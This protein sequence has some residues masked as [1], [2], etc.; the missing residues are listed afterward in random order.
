MEVR[1]H[2]KCSGITAPLTSGGYFYNHKKNKIEPVAKYHVKCLQ[3]GHSIS[4][5]DTKF[6]E[7]DEGEK[8]K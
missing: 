2:K 6:I 7:R 3:C 8:A 1:I 5:K 4:K